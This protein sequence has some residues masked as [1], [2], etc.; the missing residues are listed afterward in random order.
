MDKDKLLNAKKWL[1]NQKIAMCYI[2]MQKN[3]VLI[4]AIVTSTLQIYVM[5]NTLRVHCA[6]YFSL[7]LLALKQK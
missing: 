5:D 7:A 1:R 3:Y 2:G 4:P 6:L